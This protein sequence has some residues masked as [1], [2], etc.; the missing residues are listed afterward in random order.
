ML[1]LL[2]LF[3]KEPKEIKKSNKAKKTDIKKDNK[4]IRKGKLGEYKIDIQ[5]SQLQNDYKYTS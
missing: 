4:Y 3:K 1:F 5:L 2:K